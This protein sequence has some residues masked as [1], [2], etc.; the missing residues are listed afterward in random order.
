MRLA[1]AGEST[2][3]SRRVV[4]EDGSNDKEKLKGREAPGVGGRAAASC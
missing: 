4:N 3:E 1:Y 2:I